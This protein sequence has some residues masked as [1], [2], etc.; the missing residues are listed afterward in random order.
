M[1]VEL[2]QTVAA[3]VSRFSVTLMGVTVSP[4]GK[5]AQPIG[6]GTLVKQG[7]IFG[8]LTAGHVVR[9]STWDLTEKR[10]FTDLGIVF[11]ESEH[12][13]HIDLSDVLIVGDWN[14]GE[15]ESELDWSII[16]LP[17]DRIGYIKA[18]KSFLELSIQPESQLSSPV[19]D[20]LA[21]IVGAP[22]EFC[23]E[24]I[25]NAAD[26]QHWDIACGVF[27]GGVTGEKSFEGRRIFEVD[28]VID[29][30][31]GGPRESFGGVSGGSLWLVGVQEQSAGQFEVIS[32]ELIGVPYIERLTAN[33]SDNVV[34][35]I[36]LSCQSLCDIKKRLNEKIYAQRSN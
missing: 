16:L 27:F 36:T 5:R 10:P 28:A 29:D 4:E 11:R 26:R 30:E 17:P 32:S 21:V 6:S 2:R 7:D 20:R 22:R 15:L 23:R 13:T 1:P 12:E 24:L 35:R 33:C 14:L 8:I 3:S 18:T 19:S 25:D 34:A 31:Y 9:N